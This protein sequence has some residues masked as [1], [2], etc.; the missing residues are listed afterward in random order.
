MQSDKAVMLD[1]D[2]QLHLST[3]GHYAVE[4]FPK[5][6]VNSNECKTVLMFDINTSQQSKIKCMDKIHKQF[7]HASAENLRRLFKNTGKLNSEIINFINR[8]DS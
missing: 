8:C 3:N 1:Q 7:G 2:I 5:N 6:E 4:I